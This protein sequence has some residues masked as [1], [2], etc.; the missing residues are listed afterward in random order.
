MA[1]G[2]ERTSNAK[3][4]RE[5][6]ESHYSLRSQVSAVS[7]SGPHVAEMTT[8][9]ES[10]SWSTQAVQSRRSYVVNVPHVRQ[11][12]NWDCGLACVLMVL[13]SLGVMKCDLRCLRS[14]CPT[15][16]I[17][18]VDLAHLLRKFGVEVHFT[19]ITVG[20]N[21]DF[22]SE[23]FYRENMEEDGLRVERLFREADSI[24]ISIQCRSLSAAEIRNCVLSGHWLLIALVDKRKL[25]SWHTAAESCLPQCCVM[26]GYTGHYIVLCGYDGERQEY[27]VRDPAS[28]ATTVQIS[29]VSLEEAR[30]SFGTD[31]DLLI[32]S[33]TYP[34]ISQVEQAL[35]EAG[36]RSRQGF[37]RR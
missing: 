21:P 28:S 7:S 26:A 5:E 25:N 35:K 10:H 12:Y 19:T 16:S 31:E 15:T 17:W 36:E 33:R 30:K 2:S 24:G 23:S 13:R 27:V 9:P 14:L 6:G 37:G 4:I 29:E 3:R 20:A 1:G 11:S 8:K 32:V 18:T 34:N 22:A